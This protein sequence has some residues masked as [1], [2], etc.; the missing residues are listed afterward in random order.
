LA[1][2][3]FGKEPEFL[4]P[5]KVQSVENTRAALADG[6]INLISMYYLAS[7]P[8]E[9]I[10]YNPVSQSFSAKVNLARGTSLTVGT[11]PENLGE[12]GIRRNLG[13]GWSLE[14]KAAIDEE[15]GTNSG[16]A[17]LRWSTSY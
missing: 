2:L 1:V 9:S 4:D 6:M 15:T 8:V 11:D 13:G 5:D 12:I 14:T 17:M 7:T 10:S 3:L 16:S